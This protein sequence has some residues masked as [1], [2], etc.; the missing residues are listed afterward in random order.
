MAATLT[1]GLFP[2]FAAFATGGLET[3]LQTCLVTATVALVVSRHAAGTSVRVWSRRRLARRP[4][5]R[6]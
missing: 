1:L 6:C 5:S 3:Q 4:R 2:S